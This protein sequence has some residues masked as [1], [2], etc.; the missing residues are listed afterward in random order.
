MFRTPTPELREKLLGVHGVGPETADSILLYAGN[1]PV[2]VVDAYTK[3]ILMRHGL[4]KEKDAYEELSALF[5]GNLPRE[6]PLF[7]EYHGLIVRVGKHWCRPKE[8]R[9]EECPLGRFLPDGPA[10]LLEIQRRVPHPPRGTPNDNGK[11]R[12]AEARR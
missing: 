3:R 6:T 9:C 1:H 5:E 12:S 4:A 11:A 10:R 8:P 7:N 2:F